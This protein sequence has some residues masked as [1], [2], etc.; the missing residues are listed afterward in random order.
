MHQNAAMKSDL[1]LWVVL[2]L[3]ANS[4][5]MDPILLIFKTPLIYLA[6]RINILHEIKPEEIENIYDFI[7]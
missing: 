2:T 3:L 1:I 5:R 7:V 4:E 6:V